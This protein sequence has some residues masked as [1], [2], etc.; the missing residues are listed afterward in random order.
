MNDERYWN[1]NLLNKWFA[2][3]SIIF[4]V[5][6]IWMFIDDND[7]DFIPFKFRDVVNGKWIIFRALLSGIT[8]TVTPEWSPERYV[9]R[10]DNV[11][12][13]QGVTREVAFNFAVYPKTRQELPVLWDKL[14]YLVGLCYPS[15]YNNAPG[16][17]MKPPM[18]ELTIGDMFKNTP[19][20]LSTL[21]LTVEDGS[22]WEIDKGLQLPKHITCGCSFTYI[23]NHLPS[24]VGKHFE[25]NWLPNPAGDGAGTFEAGTEIAEQIAPARDDSLF[26]FF[27][28]GQLKPTKP[29]VPVTLDEPDI[30]DDFTIPEI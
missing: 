11:Y 19:G 30:L 28:I 22:T 15:W 10:P 21:T 12:V 17:S 4:M 9:G 6:M 5:S 13:Y 16:L 18:I 14:N 24:T 23:G 20:F 29:A 25:L 7:D 3:S 1:I 2:I 27:P 8:D 26:D